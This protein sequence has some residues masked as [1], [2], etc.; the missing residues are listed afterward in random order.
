[1]AVALGAERYEPASHSV[2]E[3]TAT[4]HQPPASHATHVVAPGDD[5]YSPAT[6]S[7][8]SLCRSL[9]AKEPGAH[10]IGSVERARQ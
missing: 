4:P 2:T 10:S 1:M 7:T 8:H 6:Q 3:L 9:A 5:W